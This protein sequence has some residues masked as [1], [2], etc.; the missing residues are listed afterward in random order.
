MSDFEAKSGRVAHF[1]D[2]GSWSQTVQDVTVEVFLEKGTRGKEVQVDIQAGGIECKV[3]GKLVF[4]G[5]F[6]EKVSTDE[7]TWT[8]EDQKLLR[9]FL[10]KSGR[11]MVQCWPSLLEK[12][13]EPDSLTLKK[14]GE[15]LELERYQ[16]EHP[17]FDFS[18][19][20][21]DKKL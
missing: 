9:I 2:W 1:T 12:Q 4:K 8:I 14:M 13:F 11:G 18:G 3:R 15:K 10:C 7:S 21:L 16:M 20:K 19:A 17:G 6:C 5:T